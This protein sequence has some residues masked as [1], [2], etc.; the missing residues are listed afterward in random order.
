MNT[1]DIYGLVMCGG[2]S[3]RMGIDKQEYVTN[4]IAI[5]FFN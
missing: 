2:K 1:S 3:S 5:N 4:K